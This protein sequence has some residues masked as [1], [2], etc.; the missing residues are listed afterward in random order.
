MPPLLLKLVFSQLPKR[1]PALMRP[2]VKAITAKANAGFIDP[3]L[4]THFRYI[5]DSLGKTGWFAGAD[6]SAADIM[7][8]FPLE[9][10]AT[11]GLDPANFPNIARFLKAIHARPAYRAALDKGGDYSYAPKN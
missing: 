9:A 3:Q 10:A 7:M 2:V 1:A 8:S 5:E 6:F 4:Q 11:R